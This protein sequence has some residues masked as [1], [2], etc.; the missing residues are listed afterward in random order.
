MVTFKHRTFFSKT[1]QKF[2]KTNNKI[3][4]VTVLQHY[5]C[6]TNVLNNAPYKIIDYILNKDATNVYIK[7]EH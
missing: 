2:Y 6:G 5:F 3:Y 7:K 1:L 4:S